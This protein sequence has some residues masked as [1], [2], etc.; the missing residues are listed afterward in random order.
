MEAANYKG[1]QYTCSPS[2]SS[3]EYRGKILTQLLP[4]EDLKKAV[5]PIHNSILG[6]LQTAI[7]QIP[8]LPFQEL[9]L[10]ATRDDL[11]AMILNNMHSAVLVPRLTLFEVV[12]KKM[13]DIVMVVTGFERDLT[14]QEKIILG[15]YLYILYVR[16]KPGSSTE[17]EEA[18]R[19][20]VATPFDKMT[21][22]QKHN[23]YSAFELQ[24]I[25]DSYTTIYTT[26]KD[27]FLPLVSTQWD[28]MQANGF[29]SQDKRINHLDI[30]KEI[31]VEIKALI[32]NIKK[33]LYVYAAV[34][35]M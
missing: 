18:Y 30:I 27:E 26:M 15:E 13:Q 25:T 19:A 3:V 21:F 20:L 10:G 29:I 11:E 28:R 33:L 8:L 23:E 17:Q 24:R 9:K 6:D 7:E 31:N 1:V 32:E 4:E 14:Q 16:N 22:I 35:C 5:M 34:A 2:S 12:R